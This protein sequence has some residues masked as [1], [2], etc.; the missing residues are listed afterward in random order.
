MLS[1]HMCFIL[2]HKKKFQNVYKLYGIIIKKQA[3]FVIKMYMRKKIMKA[4]RFIIY[5]IHVYYMD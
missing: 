5:H 3:V 2:R 4:M 1:S